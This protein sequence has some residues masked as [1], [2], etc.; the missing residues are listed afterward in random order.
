M[1][2][3]STTLIDLLGGK[4]NITNLY[5]CM[6]RLRVT[7]KD[8]GKADIDKIKELEEVSGIVDGDEFQIILGPGKAE[9]TRRAMEEALGE[10][11][12]F[13]A[14]PAQ[15]KKGAKYFLR[16]IGNIFIPLIPALVASGLIN[17]IVNFSV[18]SGVNPELTWVQ[19]LQFIGEAFFTI[20]GVLV[21][22]NTAKEFGGT[23]ALGAISGAL[24]FNPALDEMTL[25][26]EELVSGRGGLF[27]VLISAALMA[28]VEKQVRKFVPNAL[29]L[30]VTS[31]ITLLIVGLITVI[32]LQP[33]GALLSS[34]ITSGIDWVLSIGGPFAGAVLA[35]TFLP[36]VMVGLHHGLTPIHL[37]YIQNI[38]YT[39]IL[40]ILAMAGAGQVGAAMAIWV[41]TKSKRLKK[42]IGGALPVGFLGIGEPLLYG[43]TLPLGRPFITAC[44]GASLGGAYQALMTTGA[45]NIGVSGISLTPLI[46]DGKYIHYIIGLLLG[47]LGGFIL[48]YFFGFKEE[49]V[50]NLDK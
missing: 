38:G 19:L 36:L 2:E 31:T 10:I 13:E 43:V 20:I 35:S 37:D 46:A 16:K 6:T 21:G 45:I 39:P 49:M 15:K 18:N 29:D 41:K 12:Q 50:E 48:T 27:A 28:I 47:Y 26:G 24:I 33:V 32:G 5:N 4:E 22:F 40:T 3:L 42:I 1:A 14:S 30:I 11:E 25:F 44:L 17:G 7:L 34:G 8:K 9:K 23:P